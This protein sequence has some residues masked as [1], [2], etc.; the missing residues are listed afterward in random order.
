MCSGFGWAVGFGTIHTISL[1][2]IFPSLSF[3]MTQ[4]DSNKG[5]SQV[6]LPGEVMAPTA[7]RTPL[8]GFLAD[9]LQVVTAHHQPWCL[10]RWS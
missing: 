3:L 2:P 7:R 6:Q 9:F 10:I 8:S 1:M 5:D 4:P